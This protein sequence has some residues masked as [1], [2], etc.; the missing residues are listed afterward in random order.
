MQTTRLEQVMHLLRQAMHLVQEQK[1]LR[2]K[3][4][5]RDHGLLCQRMSF[6]YERKQRFVAEMLDA[7]SR[8]FLTSRGQG[9][10][11]LTG[12]DAP[13]DSLGC[14]LHDV[15]CHVW[16]MVLECHDQFREDI[17]RDCGNCAYSHIAGN[18]ALELVHAT[19]CIADRRQ[20]L[21][22][23]IEQTTPSF[24]D[25]DRTRQTVEQRLADLRFQF[26]DL[27]TKRR[28]CH[29]HLRR[30]AGKISLVRHRDEITQLM[31]FHRKIVSKG[32]LQ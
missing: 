15:Q 24:G 26:S 29:S 4:V 21:S 20:N 5:E 11:Q 27:L 10:V 32:E 6:R 3:I 12:F 13:N 19:A 7:E 22:R 14:V 17:W 9:H 31:K 30:R 25:N 16:I 2:F 18:F 28:L 1:T 8:T 23:V